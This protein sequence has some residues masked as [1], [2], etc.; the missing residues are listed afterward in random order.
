MKVEIY[1]KPV[2]V[3]HESIREITLVSTP[4]VEP[5]VLEHEEARI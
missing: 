1:E 3:R 2:I 4:R 5:D